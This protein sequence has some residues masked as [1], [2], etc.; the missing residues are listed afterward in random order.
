MVRVNWPDDCRRHMIGAAQ[1]DW[2]ASLGQFH[3]RIVGIGKAMRVRDNSRYI[4]QRNP[5]DLV[6][7]LGDNQKAPLNSEVP[8]I[9]FNFDNPSDHIGPQVPID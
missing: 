2:D 5:A 3:K 8:P 6:V 1:N 9:R 4:I 7:L